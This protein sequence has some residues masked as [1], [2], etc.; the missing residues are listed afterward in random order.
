MNTILCI[1]DDITI[2]LDYLFTNDDMS[3]YN[4]TISNHIMTRHHLYTNL[5][6]LFI[7]S[8]ILFAILIVLKSSRTR[9]FFIF[10]W[11]F[12]QCIWEIR[13]CKGSNKIKCQMNKKGNSKITKSLQFQILRPEINKRKL[14]K[15]CQ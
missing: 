12:F 6:S 8:V 11:V 2:W 13:V 9:F 1:N 14:N 7:Y 15:K 3:P 10:I 5:C 4:I